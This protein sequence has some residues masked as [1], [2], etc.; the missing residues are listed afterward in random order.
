VR[1]SIARIPD[2][3]KKEVFE[4]ATGTGL[5]PS[6]ASRD[7]MTVDPFRALLQRMNRLF[8]ETLGPVAFT[9]EENLSL[10]VWA[11][12]CDIYETDD[13]IVIKAELPGLRRED[14][15]IS[16]ENNVLTISG[17]R[18]LE[19]EAKRENYHR[20]ERSYG[21]FMRSFMLPTTVDTG[22]VSAEF[23]DGVLSVA[24]PKREE[25]KPKAIEVEA[26]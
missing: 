20:I 5:A 8:E 18:K 11:P 4:M 25:A 19:E 16:I 14:I 2:P 3:K 1:I 10:G 13:Q 23:K 9:G 21:R 15:K 26:A 7:F 17:E 6:R 24:L 22:K 12:P